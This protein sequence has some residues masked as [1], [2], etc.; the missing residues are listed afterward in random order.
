MICDVNGEGFAGLTAVNVII[1]IE[2]LYYILPKYC[3]PEETPARARWEQEDAT[4]FFFTSS[5]FS[6]PD[7]TN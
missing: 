3:K 5:S 6:S 4:G 7:A 1:I 2:I